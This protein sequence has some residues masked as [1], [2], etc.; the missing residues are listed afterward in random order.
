M[1]VYWLI[2]KV[3]RPQLQKENPKMHNSEVSKLLGTEWKSL[4][5]EG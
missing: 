4:T 2:L 1:F 3:R 5:V